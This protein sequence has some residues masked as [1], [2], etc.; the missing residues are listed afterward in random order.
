MNANPALSPTTKSFTQSASALMSSPTGNGR[1]TLVLQ[2]L[3]SLAF[4]RG[5]AGLVKEVAHLFRALL[6]A[7]VIDDEFDPC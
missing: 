6:C 2:A 7:R 1:F 4:K 3:V 5:E